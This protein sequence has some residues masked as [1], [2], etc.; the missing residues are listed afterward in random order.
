MDALPRKNFVL[1]HKRV[2]FPHKVRAFTLMEILIVMVIIAV[3]FLITILLGANARRQFVSSQLMKE[4]VVVTRSARRQ[5]M[6]VTKSVGENWVHAVGIEITYDTTLQQWKYYTV[7]LQRTSA[8]TESNT[9]YIPYP[10]NLSQYSFNRYGSEKFVDVNANFVFFRP[11][12]TTKTCNN[13]GSKLR[14]M[15]KSI[16]G[17]P[18]IY[19]DA[20]D[21]TAIGGVDVGTELTATKISIRTDGNISATTQ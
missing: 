15:F 17:T 18:V 3:L 21:I 13:P 16:N 12:S 7:K 11:G 10:T 4:F 9:F 2:A 20:Q 8:G 1:G 19:C 6:L 14:I 5:S